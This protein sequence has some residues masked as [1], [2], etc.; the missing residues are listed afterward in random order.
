MRNL[1]FLP[2]AVLLT[3]CIGA[4]GGGSGYGIGAFDFMDTG[5]AGEYTCEG[6]TGSGGS[7]S[8]DNANEVHVK[9]LAYNA[10]NAVK[11]RKANV[12]PHWFK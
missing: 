8:K 9:G 12:R 4:G 11:I 2:T 10:Q 7:T 6:V 5:G 3:G 1:F